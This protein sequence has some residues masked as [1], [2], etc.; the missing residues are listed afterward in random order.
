MVEDI[1]EKR[2]RLNRDRQKAW[3][4]RKRMARR[5]EIGAAHTEPVW[6]GHGIL[7]AP[8]SHHEST[9][10]ETSGSAAQLLGNRCGNTSRLQISEVTK[11]DFPILVAGN[12]RLKKSSL[13]PPLL[14]YT[15][16]ASLELRITTIMFP[17][18]PDH[19]LITLVQ[20]NVVRALILNMSMLSLLY[21]L[22]DKCSR[23]F[24][25]SSTGPSPPEKISKDLQ[26][27]PIQQSIP[28]PFWISA[29]PFPAL[30]DNLILMAGMYDRDDL[31][32]DLG[33]ALYEGFDDVERR[34]FL[35]WRDPWQMDGWEVTEGFVK[36]WGFLLEGCSEVVESANR[37]RDVRGEERLVVET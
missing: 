32:Y 12:A 18:S 24:G 28:H 16:D 4:D 6:H 37:W 29:I 22:P 1:A 5:A 34:G 8:P 19:Q 10:P 27:T 20:Y 36:K 3:R 15:T 17:L 7:I 13:I 35:V 14:T 26:P 11:S 21:C 23:A 33:Q 25:I 2:K 31:C 30:R 9:I